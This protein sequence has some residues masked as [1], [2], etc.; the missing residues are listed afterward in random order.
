MDQ[1]PNQNENR[2]ENRKRKRIQFGLAGLLLAMVGF[3]VVFAIYE[4]V[5]P[6]YGVHFQK[7]RELFGS[8]DFTSTSKECNKKLSCTD[9][10]EFYVY[11]FSTNGRPSSTQYMV[12]VVTIKKDDQQYEQF[13]K[14]EPFHYSRSRAISDP[15]GPDHSE[16]WANKL[17]HSEQQELQFIYHAANLEALGKGLVELGW[18]KIE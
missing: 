11:F 5:R 12:T 16:T 9:G 14:L 10:A 2:N 3:G 13:Y 4:S 18:I 8:P 6:N 1:E 15:V 7:A 17:S